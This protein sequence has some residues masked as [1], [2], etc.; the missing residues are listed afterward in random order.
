MPNIYEQLNTLAYGGVPQTSPMQQILG[1]MQP[2]DNPYINKF[3][4][5]K[6]RINK[7]KEYFKKAE[8]DAILKNVD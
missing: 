5:P 6:N 8:P 7:L 3:N 4:T 2:Q 1:M